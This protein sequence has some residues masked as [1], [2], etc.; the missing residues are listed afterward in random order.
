MRTFPKALSKFRAIVSERGERLRRVPF[1]ELKRLGNLPIEHL[2][3][4][5]RPATIGVVVQPLPDGGIRLVVQGFMKTKL[6]GQNVALDG[7]YKYSDETVIP[8]PAEEFYQFDRSLR[9]A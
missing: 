1:E 2:T 3:V 7:F 5:S 6:L 4:E 9:S 8:M